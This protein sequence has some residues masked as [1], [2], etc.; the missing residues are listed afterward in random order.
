MSQNRRGS[1][2]KIAI[3]SRERQRKA[4]FETVGYI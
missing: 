2:T 4:K 1:D 3:M